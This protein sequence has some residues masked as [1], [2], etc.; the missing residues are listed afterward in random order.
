M[1]TSVTTE[2]Q[3][4]R[5]VEFVD[6]LGRLVVQGDTA[7]AGVAI[8]A[9]WDSLRLSRSADGTTLAPSAEGMLGGRYGGVLGAAGGFTRTAAPWIPDEVAEVSDLSTALDDLFP[10]LPPRALRRGERATDAAGRTF[11]RLADSAGAARYRITATRDGD[12]PADSGRAF[13]V[14]ERESTDG[15]LVWDAHGLVAWRARVEAESRVTEG[16]QRSFRSQ[17]VQQVE[18]ARGVE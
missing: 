1:Q 13:A 15:V 9:W 12:Y 8:T 3:G 14:R 5:R 16:P 10:P 4:R 7:A 2:L 17:A 6:R 18:L 11:V